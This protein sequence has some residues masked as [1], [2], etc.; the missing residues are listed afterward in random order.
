MALSL[1]F[2]GPATYRLVDNGADV[3]CLAEN[4]LVFTGFPTM[5]DAELA[6]DA[7]YVA[8]LHWLAHR[9]GDV[10]EDAPALNVVLSEDGTSEWIG[11]EGTSVARVIR[12]P[13]SRHF[14]L[15]FLLPKGLYTAVAAYAAT[16]LYEAIVEARGERVRPEPPLDERVTAHA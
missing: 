9:R 14:E 4:L 11:P 8:L 3:G 16:H 7:G 5:H 10:R 12:S 6:A 13:D 15:E 1:V 2:E